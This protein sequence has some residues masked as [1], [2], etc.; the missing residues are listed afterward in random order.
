MNVSYGHQSL[1]EYAMGTGTKYFRDKDDNVLATVADDTTYWITGLFTRNGA[2]KIRIYDMVAHTQIGSEYSATAAD[3]ALL[4]T[5]IGAY[6]EADQAGVYS[7]FDNFVLDYT[8]HVYPL[9]G[10]DVDGGGGGAVGG[11]AL[12]ARFRRS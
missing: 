8:N 10:W 2:T 3:V 9:L 6:N 1:F 11:G 5:Y 4:S 12:L 7:Y